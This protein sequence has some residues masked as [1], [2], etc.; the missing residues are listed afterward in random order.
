MGNNLLTFDGSQ[1]FRNKLLAK[2]LPSYKIE[3]VYSSSSG[4]K[5]Y[6]YQPSDVVP[7]DTPNVS[8]NIFDDAQEATVANK[9]GPGGIVLDSGSLVSAGGGGQVSMNQAG[10][11]DVNDK[12]SESQQPYSEKS[13]NLQLL[14]DFYVDA[15]AVVNRYSPPGGYNGTFISTENIQPKTNTKSGEYPNFL[16]PDFVFL[17]PLQGGVV[18]LNDISSEALSNFSQDSYLQQISTIYLADAFRERVNREIEKNTIG[19]VNLQAFSDVFSASL[20]A[21]GQQGLVAKN[22]TITVPDGPI[23]QVS[24]LLQRFSGT[25]IPTSPIEGEYF[26][27]PQ[28]QKTKAG[29]LVQSIFNKFTKPATPPT[30]SKK[31]LN[32]TGSGQK[33]VLFENLGYNRFKP[34]YE[35]NTTQ[36]GVVVD[37]LFN[38]NNSLTNFYVGTET[39]DP[40]RIASPSDQVPYDAYGNQ[41]SSIVLGPDGLAKEYEGTQLEKFKFGLASLPYDED[42]DPTGGFSWVGQKTKADA[43]KNAGPGGENFGINPVF[44]GNVGNKFG[45][46]ESTSVE[47]KKGSILDETQRLIDSAPISG[48]KRLVHVGNA[49]NQVSKVF[50]D[51][52]KELTKGSRVRKFVNKNGVEVGQE[53]GRVFTKDVPYL[54]YQNLQSTVANSDGLETNGN[55]RKFTYSVLDSTYNLNIAPT[56]GDESTNIK[57]GRVK[58]Y[59]FSI[60]NLA[61]RNT[62]EFDALPECEKGPN[63]GRIMWFPPYDL[64]LDTEQ[65]SPK[66]NQTNFLGRPE[67]IYTYDTTSRSGGISWSIIVDHPSVT[68]LIVKKE[69]ERA[70]NN[71]ATQVLAS[72]FAGCKKYDIYELARKYSTLGRDTIEQV[73]QKVLESN[74][75][76]PEQK[77]AAIDGF[78]SSNIPESNEDTG[79]LDEYV[80]FGF[81]F[82][83]FTEGDGSKNYE[84]L[85]TQYTSQ[86]TLYTEQNQQN[87]QP[88]NSFF[89]YVLSQ[90]TAKML[91]LRS[92]IIQMLETEKGIV[93]ITMN[94]TQ[95]L[96]GGNTSV[97]D[98]WFDSAKLYFTDTNV[99]NGKTIKDYENSGKIVFKKN[100]LGTLT[101]SQIQL[102]G[103]APEP[104]DCATSQGTIYSFYAMACR[105]V[106][107]E[108]VILT[109]APVNESSGGATVPNSEVPNQNVLNGQKPKQNI[110]LDVQLKGL[111][112]KLI[113]ELLT[114]SNYFEVL[115]STDSFIYDSIKNK[116]K[117]F[118]PAFHS[119]TPEGLNA[120]L[121]FLN[122]CMRPG[123]TIPTK[124]ENGESV[125]K[126]SFNTNFGTPPILVLRFGDF[127]N[128]KIV[129][130]SFS[131]SYEPLL[132]LNPEG[133]GVQPMI[134]KISL[135]FDMIGGHGLKGPVEQLQN[136]LSF[137][138]YANTEMYDER[139]EATEDTTAVD[140][141]LL[142]ALYNE[143]PIITVNNV[144]KTTQNEGGNTFGLITQV[145]PGD[146]G[147]QSGSTQYKEFF[148]GFIT[149]TSDYFTNL[150]T[151][152]KNLVNEY[153]LGIWAQINITRQFSEGYINNLQY[154]DTQLLKIY[155]KPTDW[156]A[157]IQELGETL[158]E[159]INDEDDNLSSNINISNQI[160]NNT[161]KIMIDNYLALVDQQISSGFISIAT[162]IQNMS[163]LQLKMTNYMSKMDVVAF[164]GDGKILA[165][166]NTKIYN[167]SGNS[168]NGTDSIVEFYN[169]YLE[170]CL[171]ETTSI[172]TL[173][174]DFRNIIFFEP[175]YLIDTP[176]LSKPFY[177]GYFVLGYDYDNLVYMVFGKTILDTAKKE[178]FIADI[179]KNITK[180]ED[181]PF[182]TA[183]VTSTIN[184]WTPS[185]KSQK[186]FE[187]E[188]LATQKEEFQFGGYENFN[189]QV[190]G[191]SIKDKDRPTSF[192]TGSNAVF[193]TALKNIYASVNSGPA[194]KF[195]GKK[196]FN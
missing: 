26:Q 128:T 30:A 161:K 18:S 107:I 149:V 9:Y 22:W 88:V 2:N 19:R 93:E 174:V 188:F 155:G 86:Q 21:S 183:I 11:G 61:W 14:N 143:E 68:D 186:E 78:P 90:N 37:N 172:G 106:K 175:N 196:Q 42:T 83:E 10:T 157:N 85:N 144:N 7:N 48:A 47:F 89:Q 4:N 105:A 129:P 56:N 152:Y 121:V 58:K 32:N 187:K 12:S 98:Q 140:K 181:K 111:S 104:V 133:I 122:Q 150:F 179:T 103:P 125:V 66:F 137:N 117:F 193:D 70:D 52:Y 62:P 101:T 164:S 127:Y 142:E 34:D 84:L 100:N 8:E 49:I 132:D 82:P 123:R 35:Q 189:P 71:L 40:L 92:N 113:R 99:G 119:I 13:A 151:N 173:E 191:V 60:E 190:N 184:G 166:G 126:D 64:K 51:G 57:D 138:Y 163:D 16:F 112:K 27:T 158:K 145:T 146:N 17:N 63:G 36:I 54:T 91:D 118:N 171:G 108:K 195:N 73:Y 38:K 46:S 81:Y 135:G 23:D 139:A 75:T 41:T 33:S 180:E 167:L 59:M 80:N 168:V 79:G 45:A 178:K 153:G 76:S 25:Y 109:P 169:D 3:G 131:I 170:V 69:L 182:A 110:N 1:E 177:K 102:D 15:A 44:Q 43:G 53:Y 194:D 192:V 6:A 31:F 130:Q 94:G 28:R 29:Q 50:N 24:F 67:P 124:Q 116:F 134:A 162:Y 65:S 55:I 159:A 114:E 87:L 148:N 141:A 72:F 147:V 136:A 165:D 97:S 20:L 160:S 185:F 77:K 74:Q 115:K 156:Q 96:G 39:N 176:Q 154:P 120:R 95:I 5:T